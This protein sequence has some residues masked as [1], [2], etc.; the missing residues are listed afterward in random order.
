MPL[1]SWKVAEVGL[2]PSPVLL[3]TPVP[4]IVVRVWVERESI[5]IWECSVSA[6][7]ILPMLSPQI[8]E[9]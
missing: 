5:F 8:P 9:E 1:G 4:A 2:P 3:A 7:N 6:M